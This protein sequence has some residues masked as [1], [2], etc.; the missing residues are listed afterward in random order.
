M[1]AANLIRW[2]GLAAMG[3]GIIFAGI[4]PI[5]PPDV[6]ASVTTS[7]WAV[8]IGS[9]A[10]GLVGAALVVALL[11]RPWPGLAGVWPVLLGGAVGAVAIACF[12]KALAMGTMSIVA[13][14]SATSS[15]RP[16]VNEMPCSTGTSTSPRW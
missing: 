12:Y 2:S 4:Q 14:I 6:L 9:Q 8:V 10:A 11:G 5:H 3:A 16:T 15:P 7:L 1:K 13:P